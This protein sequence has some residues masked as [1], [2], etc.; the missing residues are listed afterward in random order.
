MPIHARW[1]DFGLLVAGSLLWTAIAGVLL[2]SMGSAL[3]RAMMKR[4]GVK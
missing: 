4:L 1:L 3:P 2:N